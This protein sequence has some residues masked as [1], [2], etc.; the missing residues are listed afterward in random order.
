MPTSPAIQQLAA[1]FNTLPPT[2]K[3]VVLFLPALV[4][5]SYFSYLSWD[6]LGTLGPDEKV[7]AILRREVI[8]DS[9]WAQVNGLQSQI[10]EQQQKI[11]KR[12]EYER[13]LRDLQ[14]QIKE[15]EDIL[16]TE[17]DKTEIRQVIQALTKEV[18]AEFGTV[19]L[20][21]VNISEGV[22]KKGDNYRSA[23]YSIE[24][25]GELNA[26]I[27]YIDLLEKPSA[28]NQRFMAVNNV[29]LRPG[30]MSAKGNSI[31]YGPHSVLISLVTY[32][33]QPRGA[34]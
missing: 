14:D 5:V 31:N 21:S 9:L 26:I 13:Q 17:Q 2:Q 23:T 6:L 30:A 8:S 28:K 33:Y 15:I 16:P 1:R 24:V 22:A 4:L 12:K 3:K 25:Q 29:T 27:S 10:D 18:P 11:D 20:L 34:K 19:T 7:P 32:I